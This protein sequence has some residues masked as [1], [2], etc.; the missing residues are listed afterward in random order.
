MASNHPAREE[1]GVGEHQHWFVVALV[2]YSWGVK[3]RGRL[4]GDTGGLG[5]GLATLGTGDMV[6]WCARV[7]HR[8]VGA[9]WLVRGASPG[10]TSSSSHWDGL[11]GWWVVSPNGCEDRS[12]WGAA[13]KEFAQSSHL[14]GL[15]A[16]LSVC[17]LL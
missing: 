3:K 13:V 5:G 9:G 15:S 4:W 8:W 2:H 6:P 14:A 17:T 12:C 10:V 1:E 11:C 7:L 16:C